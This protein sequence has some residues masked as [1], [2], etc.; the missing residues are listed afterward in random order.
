MTGF[1]PDRDPPAGRDVQA[2]AFPLGS[3]SGA[4]SRLVI[5]QVATT[6]RQVTCT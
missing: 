6:A 1:Q 5:G 4:S 3:G 2:A